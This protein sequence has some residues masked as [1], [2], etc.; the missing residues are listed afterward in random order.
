M[1]LKVLLVGTGITSAVTGMCLRKSLS[2]VSL[3]IW[4]KAKGIGGRMSTSRS[5]FDQNCIADLGAQYITTTDE[6]IKERFEIYEPLLRE[7]I[8]E[9]MNCKI[10]GMKSPKNNVKN[11][12]ALRGSSSIVKHCI[13]LANINEICFEHHINSIS[14]QG[15][16]WLV[17]TT[18][19]VEG[20]FDIVIL[21]MPVPQIL[22]L[23]GSIAEILQ[24]KPNMLDELS[25]VV[26]NSR[27]ALGLFYNDGVGPDVDWDAQYFVDDPILRYVAIDNQKRQIKSKVCSVVIHTTKEYGEKHVEDS[28]PDVESEL[29]SYINKRFPG[30]PVPKAVKCHKWRFSQVRDIY[31]GVPGCITISS[32]PVLIAGGDGFVGSTFDNCVTSAKSITEQVE[33]LI[34]QKYDKV[35]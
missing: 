26:Y 3:V 12:I 4:D 28:I 30:W 25:S 2:E 18:S 22:Q 6:I 29:L 35:L 34:S 21:T 32:D 16:K 14:K 23:K 9:P 24:S 31:S 17:K 20:E 13:E 10:V 15:N 11:F 5:S 8:L 27:Y 1:S 19:G 7:G 33:R